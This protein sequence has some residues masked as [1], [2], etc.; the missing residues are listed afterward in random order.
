MHH[1]TGGRGKSPAM[2]TCS[3]RLSIMVDQEAESFRPE[4]MAGRLFEG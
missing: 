1:T 2:G 3:R 4:E